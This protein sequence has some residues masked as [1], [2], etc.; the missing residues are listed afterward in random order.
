M[1][2]LFAALVLLTTQPC[3]AALCARGFLWLKHI[4]HGGPSVRYIISETFLTVLIIRCASLCRQLHSGHRTRLYR[5]ESERTE[6]RG[7]IFSTHVL[8]AY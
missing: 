2:A 3:R 6:R 8:S 7:M 4:P 5:N 1:I